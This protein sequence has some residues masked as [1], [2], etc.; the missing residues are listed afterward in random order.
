MSQKDEDNRDGISRTSDDHRGSHCQ[1]EKN[2]MDDISS[3]V[4]L[5]LFLMTVPVQLLFVFV[6]PHLLSSLLDHASHNFLPFSVS[7]IKAE[8]L[9]YSPYMVL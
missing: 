8:A 1:D 9:S 6:L 2:N 4:N 7:I 3:H 5:F